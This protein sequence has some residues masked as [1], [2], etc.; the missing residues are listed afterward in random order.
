MPRLSQT[1]VNALT[2]VTFLISSIMAW[3]LVT[4]RT[5]NPFFSEGLA[6]DD[7]GRGPFFTAQAESLLRGELAVP[8]ETLYGE[9]FYRGQECFGYFG[10]TPSLFRL[11]WVVTGASMD[12]TSLSM[13]VALI[14]G[15]GVGLALLVTVLKHFAPPP[16]TWGP[17]GLAL[18][19]LALIAFGPGNLLFQVTD[20]R[21]FNEAVAWATTLLLAAL[22]CV[23][24]WARDG[25]SRWLFLAVVL[26]TLAA[27]ARPSAAMGAAGI[28]LVVAL[29]LF[30]RHGR[31]VSVVVA[32]FLL[33]TLPLGL[34]VLT[35]MWKFGTPTPDL[36]LNESISGNGPIETRDKWVGVLEANGGDT[37]SPG[38]L[39]SQAWAAL[40]PDAVA[41]N[42][43]PPRNAYFTR[44]SPETFAFVPPTPPG[45]L[46]VQPTGS[47]TSLVA[48][49]FVLSV[50]A[51][52]GALARPRALQGR[53][54]SLVALAVGSGL[55]LAITWT[56][57]T[58]ANRFLLDAWPMVSLA[59]CVGIAFLMNSH[60][61]PVLKAATVS[62]LGILTVTSL[63]LSR[64]VT[65]I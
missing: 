18:F 62:G 54:R 58:V 52:V 30:R 43:E 47:L 53:I 61:R 15:I 23:V 11:P 36:L 49:P 51:I 32:V 56:T 46:Y 63:A 12:L 25:R 37:F 9:C 44:S 22:L 19:V 1:W 60:Q 27:N 3:H 35:Y 55:G 48:G 7:Y 28:G 4:G 38:F 39:P 5:W 50:I 65:G 45:G 24:V 16:K 42:F 10:L 34:L 17:Y 13:V 2:T 64:M 59:G 8:P 21:I 26:S 29:I 31:R 41:I 14:L 33:I 40:R 6:D 20:P 57:V